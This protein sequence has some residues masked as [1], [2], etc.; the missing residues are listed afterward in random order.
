MAEEQIKL[1]K[2]VYDINAV[3]TKSLWDSVPRWIFIP[4][5]VMTMKTIILITALSVPMMEK[6]FSDEDLPYVGRL[7]QAQISLFYV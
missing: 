2:C 1:K 7:R 5:S 4:V 3:I 6:I